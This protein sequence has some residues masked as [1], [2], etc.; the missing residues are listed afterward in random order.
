[1]PSPPK[2]ASSVSSAGSPGQASTS[3]TPEFV[4]TPVVRR[5]KVDTAYFRGRQDNYSA[6]GKMYKR[7]ADARIRRMSRPDTKHDDESRENLMCFIEAA[8][9]V[10]NY[11]YSFW[12]QDLQHRPPPGNAP[13]STVSWRSLNGMLQMTLKRGDAAARSLPKREEDREAHLARVTACMAML[14]RFEG[15]MHSFV[16]RESSAT[17][18]RVLEAL[19][20]HSHPAIN[21]RSPASIS[22]SPPGQQPTPPAVP[23]PAPQHS[24]QTRGT[25]SPSPAGGVSPREM[26]ALKEALEDASIAATCL[27]QA[28]EAPSLRPDALARAFPHT[29]RRLVT[30]PGVAALREPAPRTMGICDELALD[31]E[32]AAGDEVRG[33]RPHVV[34]GTS[35][36]EWPTVPSSAP[37]A[38]IGALCCVTRAMFWEM[39]DAVG[40]G[41]LGTA[42]TA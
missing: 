26:L 28:H 23:S 36:L 29:F 19:R 8:D 33:A 27:G 9:S 13:H 12:L 10:M 6:V 42:Q 2:T 24:P 30:A 21:G 16:G 7:A 35:E 14:K 34:L 37:G 31:L 22:T 17:A 15:F 4:P 41:G 20:S 38:G 18:S 40:F 25:L 39:G 3:S 1:M 11:A 5:E 32:T